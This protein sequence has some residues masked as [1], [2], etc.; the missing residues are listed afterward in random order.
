[1][2]NRDGLDREE[3]IKRL[4]KGKKIS[5]LDTQK[6]ALI[7]QTI[8]ISKN[9]RYYSHQYKQQG[10]FGDLIKELKSHKEDEKQEPS[11]ALI[12]IFLENLEKISCKF[13]ERWRNY[14]EWYLEN[15]LKVKPL[16]KEGNKIWVT[17]QK[18]HSDHI[19][20]NKDMRFI[21]HNDQ[22]QTLYY[23]P[24]EDLE[25]SNTTLE[26]A[27]IVNL[28]KD[29]YKVP[30]NSLN[31]VTSL[32]VRDIISNDNLLK[33]SGINLK[34]IGIKLTS[35]ALLLREGKRIVKIT[36]YSDKNWQE[37]V[38]KV[39]KDIRTYNN[40]SDNE[41]LNKQFEGWNPNQLYKNIFYLTISTSEGWKEIPNYTITRN[42]KSGGLELMFTLDE[43]FPST[44]ACTLEKHHFITNFPKLNIHLNFDA[45]MYPY[46]WIKNLLINRIEIKTNVYSIGNIQ[47]YNDLGK[48]D[49]STPFAPFGI[50]IRKG[51]WMTVG[52][53]EMA[54]KNTKKVTLD[55]R[56]GQ[57][58]DDKEGL[59]GYYRLYDQNINNTSFTLLPRFLEN[60]EWKKTTDSKNVYLFSTSNNQINNRPEENAPLYHKS[61]ISVQGLD[62]MTPVKTPEESYE[63]N[64]QSRSGF[65]SFSLNTPEMGFG[66]AMYHKIF[67]EQLMKKSRALKN[68]PTINPPIQP[69]IERITLSYEAEDVINLQVPDK[70][71]AVDY[72]IP[73]DTLTTFPEN[74]KKSIF[75]SIQLDETNLLFALKNPEPGKEL[76]VFFDFAPEPEE[77][78]TYFSQPIQ[79]YIGHMRNWREVD[80]T[81]FIQKDET[82]RLLVS[83]RIQFRLPNLIA[84]DLYDHE[85]L[86]W[87]R[88]GIKGNNNKIIQLKSI[89]LNP[90][91][92]IM[93]NDTLKSEV[94]FK[95][96]TP[97]LKPE[98]PIPGV[99]A[100]H[101]LTPFFEG[102]PHET[103]NDRMIRISEYITHQGRAVT[104][105][106]YE[107]L[108]LQEFTDIGKVLCYREPDKQ[109]KGNRVNI[110]LAILPAIYSDKPLVSNYIMIK[111]ERYLSSLNTQ[112]VDKIK[113]TNPAY[114]Q[115]LVR[116]I[117][118]HEIDPSEEK[119][120]EE[121]LLYFSKKSS[122]ELVQLINDY[123]AP[124]QSKKILPSFGFNIHLDK[125]YND[126]ENKLKKEQISIDRFQV[127]RFKNKNEHYKIYEYKMGHGEDTD[128]I[129][130]P[131]E[132]N[133]I[134]IPA[135]DHI[136]HVRHKNTD[137]NEN[138]GIGEIK[139]EDT[140]IITEN[141]K[142]NGKEE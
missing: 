114:E 26:K 74:E 24:T 40:S 16:P 82:M 10:N 12:R 62:E 53:F 47:I 30:E 49:S 29:V 132:A 33:S 27:Y 115:I 70:Q 128:S 142:H 87:I 42:K 68:Y 89:N 44:E 85:N 56:W 103:K 17:L 20:I 58:P 117:L 31:M 116:V 4:T 59:F 102:R 63:Y 86:L 13:N 19:T 120:E 51:S 55:I 67:V 109:Q 139:L 3:R 79:W 39:I 110:V 138:F 46:S 14:P 78:A 95:S 101:S 57:I 99:N 18:S 123:I 15:V 108:L 45:W 23:S 73:I 97:I 35:P 32:N 141:T 125:M 61:S 122:Q 136:I 48:I 75:F 65:V 80:E 22:Q 124:W 83:G 112:Y 96:V 119:I 98:K 93:N 104:P 77:I 1:M 126:I 113:I 28:E 76:N 94:S 91:L 72:I 43:K 6:N 84:P 107:R 21:T 81:L 7:E 8:Q 64:Q 88:A 41:A 105:R 69:L 130:V 9:V 111:A 140:F 121:G 90:V 66:E 36:F 134:F 127:F 131:E 106:D 135:K 37:N 100:C 38:I 2:T 60:Y 11:I 118:K 25:L 92:L 52:N 71:S 50:N 5:V 34:T 54:V 133:K 129:I 137:L